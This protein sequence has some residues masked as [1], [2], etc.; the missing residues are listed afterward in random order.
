M[1]P[2]LPPAGQSFRP[3]V[4]DCSGHFIAPSLP[5]L[6]AKLIVKFETA[7]L[8]LLWL[9]GSMVLPL[10]V[11]ADARNLLAL[12]GRNIEAGFG[13]AGCL[14]RPCVQ[15]QLAF[16][17]DAITLFRLGRDAFGRRAK[18]GDAKSL[19]DVLAVIGLAD[20]DGDA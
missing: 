1:R 15:G 9:G 19:R 7:A 11:L 3:P 2:V 12:P 16:D 13:F 14:V 10:A 5:S 4:P 20:S 17:I 8:L 18:A 6:K